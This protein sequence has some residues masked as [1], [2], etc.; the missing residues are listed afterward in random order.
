MLNHPALAAKP[1]DQELGRKIAELESLQSE[2][3]DRELYLTNLRV[4][5]AAFERRYTGIVGKRYAEIDEIE[6]KI[7]EHFS[8]VHPENQRAHDFAA[9][10]RSQ[11]QASRTNVESSLALKSADSLP[12]RS[13]TL[14]NLYREVAKRIH[15]DL[16]TSPADRLVREK[17]MADANRAFEEGDEARLRAILEEYNS[18]PEAVIGEG[19]AADLVRVIRKIAQAKRRLSE[20]EKEVA[21]LT[22]SELSEL[23]TR[24][25]LAT[26][27]GR[28]LLKEMSNELDTQIAALQDRLESLSV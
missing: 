4:D 10:A 27:E 24:V 8:R 9:Q 3:A 21:T 11:A 13:Q 14:K 16:A 12:P 5:L 23:K 19:T 2:L 15:P 18:S 22:K 20:I 26:A 6:A 7:A 17:L 25:D 28:D 1:E